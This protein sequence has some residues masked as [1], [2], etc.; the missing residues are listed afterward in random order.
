MPQGTTPVDRKPAVV[1]FNE[2]CKY[3][4]ATCGACGINMTICRD[5]QRTAPTTNN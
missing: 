4:Y 1:C 5:R 3:C 2:N